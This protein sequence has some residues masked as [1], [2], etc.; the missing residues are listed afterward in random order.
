MTG[1]HSEALRKAGLSADEKSI[2][3]SRVFN[4]PREQV[5]RAWT[6]P[7]AIAQWFGPKGF[8]TRVDELDFR[9]GGRS[10]Y[11]MIGPDGA[12]Y[13]S[14]GVFRE[15]V[16][17]EKI[18]TT[19]EFGEDYKA[20]SK[21]DLPRGMVLTCFFEDAGPG[22]TLLTLHIAHPDAEGRRKH[23]EM[24]VVAGWGSTLDCLEEYLSKQ[25]GT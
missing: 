20:S 7:G 1:T 11:T 6:D 18:V 14:V 9:P 19:D 17:M 25:G 13:P 12:E 15:V 5:W 22:R 24:G 16:P 8:S 10:K 3:I 4:A 2:V 23:E 21:D